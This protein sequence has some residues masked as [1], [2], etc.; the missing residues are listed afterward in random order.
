[1]KNTDHSFSAMCRRFIRDE[2]NAVLDKKDALYLKITKRQN[3][4][5][6]RLSALEGRPPASA[7]RKP[8][9][10]RITGGSLIA[11]R[12]RVGISQRQLATLMD[13]TP[14]RVCN[15][16]KDLQRPSPQHRNKF[17]AL[18]EKSK[19]EIATIIEAS[20]GNKTITTE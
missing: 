16:E 20:K 1:M 17:I 7:E 14:A 15:W 11:F 19:K 6:Q 8:R 9:P 4:Q 2:V 3:E 12:K 13:T 5:E 18:R 10:V